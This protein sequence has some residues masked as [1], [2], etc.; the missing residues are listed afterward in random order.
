[1]APVNSRADG[2]TRFLRETGFLRAHAYLNWKYARNS[3]P[4]V[5]RITNA[6]QVP[7]QSFSVFQAI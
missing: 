7:A 5:S 3:I 4:F 2:E 1:M 6:W